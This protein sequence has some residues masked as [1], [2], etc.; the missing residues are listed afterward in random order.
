MSEPTI[1]YNKIYSAIEQ[2]NSNPTKENIDKRNNAIA[3]SVASVV[4]VSF[5]TAFLYDAFKAPDDDDDK[6]KYLARALEALKGNMIGN[7]MG[8]IPI[9]KDI[10]SMFQGFASERMELAGLSDMI[11]SLK[12]VYKYAA[13][14]ANGEAPKQNIL[15][16]VRDTLKKAGDLYGIPASNVVKQ[17]EMIFKNYVA[18]TN[19]FELVY[20]MEKLF[21]NINNSDNRTIYTGI[22]TRELLQSRADGDKTKAIAI[23]DDMVLNGIPVSKIEASVKGKITK[24]LTNK[25]EIVETG[26][27]VNEWNDLPENEKTATKKSEIIAKYDKIVADL[28]KKGYTKE[29]VD[30]ATKIASKAGT[31]TPSLDRFYQA[32]V[33][34]DP[35]AEA[36][37]DK[38]IDAGYTDEDLRMYIDSKS[39]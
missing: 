15:F 34:K 23:Y 5:V 7:V 25:S 29:E 26:M 32:Y 16:V 8:T 12:G 3:S 4:A 10:Y 18:Q 17:V 38:L 35:N 9:V 22:L 27:M 24:A 1:M 28:V 30:K 20:H 11:I 14:V 36:M 13:S 37:Y 19:D 31:V 2:A 33:A 39:K 6:E 21:T